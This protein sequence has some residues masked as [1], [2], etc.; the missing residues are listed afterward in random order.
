MHFPK[1]LLL[2]G[3]IAAAFIAAP[4]AA[5]QGQPAVTSQNATIQYP[6]PFTPL[7]QGGSGS[8]N[9]EFQIPGYTMWSLGGGPPGTQLKDG[10]W[11][12]SWTPP[13]SNSTATYSFNVAH[14]GSG[15]LAVA[16]SPSYTLTVTAPTNGI[17]FNSVTNWPATGVA[18]S[19]ITFTANVTNTGTTTWGSGT[20]IL[21]DDNATG[22]Q[23]ASVPISGT[24]GT[25]IAVVTFSITLTST[26][27][28]DSYNITAF[29][30]GVG[31]FGPN[32]SQA[33][34]IVPAAPVISSATTASVVVNTSFYYQITT[35]VQSATSFNATNLP[36]GLS[37]NTSTGVITGTPSALGTTNI[38]LS[39]SNAG[40]TGVANLALSVVQA[41]PVINS[42]TTATGTVGVPFSYQI[43]ATNSPFTGY[44]ATSLP[45]GLSVNTTTGLISGTPTTTANA[46][47]NL[48][49]SNSAGTGTQSLAYTANPSA[50]TITSA[51]SGTATLGVAYSYQITASGQSITG[52]NATNL[53]AGLSVNR[54]TGLISGTPTALGATTI[55]ISA[56]N[57]G[58][59]GS[60]N[61]AL[62]V[63][64]PI[65]VINS[66]LSA[67]ATV[68][69]PFSYQITATNP[70]LT[71][72][73]ASNLPGGLSVNTATGLISGTPVGVI[74]SN[75]M[76]SATNAGGTGTTFVTITVSQP[77]NGLTWNSVSGWPA[78]APANSHVSFSASVT[79]SGTSAWVPGYLI[80]VVDNTSG[81]QVASTP[82]TA[83]VGAT[84]SSVAFSFTLSPTVGSRTYNLEGYQSGVGFFG[85]VKSLTVNLG[86]GVPGITS[87]ATATGAVG[88]FF[89]YAIQA[90]YSPTSYAAT[91]LPPG[92][93]IAAN[94]LISGTPTTAGG[95]SITISA[96]NAAGTGSAT[97]VVT[98]GAVPIITGPASA[99][100]TAGSPFSCQLVFQNSPTSF[101]ATGLPAGLTINAAGLISGT[102]TTAGTSTASITATN[103]VG[104]GPAFNLPVTIQGSGLG[105]PSITSAGTATATVGSIFV[106]QITATNSPSSYTATGLP[107]GVSVNTATGAITG[108]PTSATPATSTVALSA[109]NGGTP[110][111][112]NLVITMTTTTSSVPSSVLSQL[113]V[114]ASALPD[115][116]NAINIQ[117][118]KPQNP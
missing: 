103:A 92:L 21:V 6:G 105:T 1:F 110:G 48:S 58:G 94:G 114:S 117:V 60:A 113:G 30:S 35:S 89:S 108:V 88:T 36:S 77:A 95:F 62:T 28:P 75:V 15:S 46:T 79:N 100:G 63:V 33:I 99:S 2:L 18:G 106:Y 55:A 90:T 34:T 7:Y 78:T 91:P 39:A 107:T 74:T 20:S 86:P 13:L 8:G 37:I 32:Q 98:I 31:S 12:T 71:R 50:P 76:V 57:A 11:V 44:N 112:K 4:N 59:T 68:G 47:I 25:N 53:P 16:V 70:P 38:N 40:G 96:T 118:L 109:S 111:T 9:W 45:A 93:S 42:P 43:T 29:Q 69:L 56:T 81:L 27:G 72:Y 67:P 49:V 73:N 84:L 115:S 14:L 5:A 10:T 87:A 61:L 102:P 116:G 23:V 51:T 83:A 85:P 82:V 26:L 80:A 66:P 54:T 19:S 17:T 104:T 97:L 52:Y 22:T 64:P 41:V 101:N 24:P 65:P 3:S